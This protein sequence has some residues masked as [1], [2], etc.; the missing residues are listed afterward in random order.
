[1]RE[2]LLLHA[3]LSSVH[4]YV[5]VD[6]FNL[7][8]RDHNDNNYCYY[9][10]YLFILITRKCVKYMQLF[11][12]ACR[13]VVRHRSVRKPVS[14]RPRIIRHIRSVQVLSAAAV[15]AVHVVP[16]V[17]VTYFRIFPQL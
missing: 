7:A 10:Y 17:N 2:I 9:Y 15:A 12:I 6:H 14:G 1:M 13:F 8:P 3:T 5:Y 16:I 11:E 4:V